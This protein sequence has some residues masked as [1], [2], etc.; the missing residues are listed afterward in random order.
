MFLRFCE[1][2]VTVFL[3]SIHIHAT[4]Y[5]LRFE[6]LSAMNVVF[7]VFNYPFL[8]FLFYVIHAVSVMMS[9]VS[10]VYLRNNLFKS[11]IYW[12]I[13]HCLEFLGAVIDHEA[14]ISHF[15]IN[16]FLNWHLLCWHSWFSTFDVHKTMNVSKVSVN[17]Y[18]YIKFS[19]YTTTYYCL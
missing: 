16:Y 7:R 11:V 12:L 18:I 14:N 4:F 2:S 5:C 6:W 10:D 1:S 3:I 13:Y 19:L 17:P 8:P 9:S 15:W